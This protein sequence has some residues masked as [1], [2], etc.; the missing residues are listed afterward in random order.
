M[1]PLHFILML[2]MLASTAMAYHSDHYHDDDGSEKKELHWYHIVTMIFCFLMFSIHWNNHWNAALFVTNNAIEFLKM[3]T[4]RS[5]DVYIIVMCKLLDIAWDLVTD[6]I[7]SAYMFL[8]GHKSSSEALRKAHE[9]MANKESALAD[10]IHQL[11]EELAH[12][13]EAGADDTQKVKDDLAMTT[14]KRTDKC[15]SCPSLQ[16]EIQFL[17]AKFRKAKADARTFENSSQWFELQYNSSKKIYHKHAAQIKEFTLSEAHAWSQLDYIKKK[18]EASMSKAQCTENDS[19]TTKIQ[20][21]SINKDAIIEEL[22]A[23]LHQATSS[24]DQAEAA[25]KKVDRESTEKDATITELEAQLR[26]ANS[27]KDQAKTA[28]EESER[29]SN[30]KDVIIER[31]Q[32]QVQENLIEKDTVIKNLNAQIRESSKKPTFSPDP[33]ALLAAIETA[34]NEK[35]AKDAVIKK[36]EDKLKAFRHEATTYEEKSTQKDDD[37]IEK[38]EKELSAQKLTGV[39]LEYYQIVAKDSS[40]QQTEKINKLDAKVVDLEDKIKELEGQKPSTS[41]PEMPLQEA[42]D[43]PTGLTKTKTDAAPAK[44][45]AAGPSVTASGSVVNFVNKSFVV[46]AGLATNAFK[47]AEKETTAPSAQALASA[48]AGFSV[49]SN[50]LPMR[51]PP[52]AFHERPRSPSPCERLRFPSPRTRRRVLVRVVLL[53]LAKGWVKSSESVLPTHDVP[54]AFSMVAKT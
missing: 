9:Q 37:T 25:T 6:R 42:A 15:D 36:L 45:E 28:T 4:A 33:S 1:S 44:K 12:A 52:Q 10:K 51:T 8:S 18:P 31:I 46:S 53:R 39:G 20:Q 5:F 38:L 50:S 35:A 54:K 43:K 49:L 30:E 48:F 7:P 2:F 40:A 14:K 11:Q 29:Q 27:S 3:A 13:K 41:E 26:Q 34:H 24:K 47:D 21:E 23:Q 16:G 32:A 22:K 19:A 17:T